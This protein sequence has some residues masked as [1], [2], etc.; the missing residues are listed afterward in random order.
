MS[1]ICESLIN[2]QCE[3]MVVA[4]EVVAPHHTKC[5]FQKRICQCWKKYQCEEVVV[6]QHHH[7]CFQMHGLPKKESASNLKKDQCPKSAKV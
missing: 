3:E 7:R 4:H 6:A 2:I 5:G 1:Q